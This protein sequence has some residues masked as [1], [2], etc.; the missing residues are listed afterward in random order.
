MVC[1]HGGRGSFACVN[2]ARPALARAQGTHAP[3]PASGAAAACLARQD[4][5]GAVVDPTGRV[6]DDEGL[7]VAGAS[8]M[9]SLPGA[10]TTV[11]TFMTGEQI[12]DHRGG[13]L[14]A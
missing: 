13:R 2:P 7:T 11:P 10:D 9:S 5:A 1:Q 12:A 14:E 6:T 4:E 8:W 3:E